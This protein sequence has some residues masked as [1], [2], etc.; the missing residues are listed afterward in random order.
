MNEGGIPAGTR[1]TTRTGFLPIEKVEPGDEVL[2]H[3][4]RYRTV[5]STMQR[6]VDEGLSSRSRSSKSVAQHP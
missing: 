6:Q 4:G 3:I 5:L 2:T 1:I